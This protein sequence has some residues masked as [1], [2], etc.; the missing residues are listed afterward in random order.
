[1]EGEGQEK[2]NSEAV[3][4]AKV[5][6]KPLKEWKLTVGDGGAETGA[7]FSH[8]GL[9]SN[10]REKTIPSCEETRDREPALLFTSSAT[11][12]KV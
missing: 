10:F 8:Q 2:L 5:S 6:E 4:E 3:G 11:V 1:M 9:F 12:S 7:I